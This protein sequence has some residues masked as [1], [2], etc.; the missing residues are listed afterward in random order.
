MPITIALQLGKKAG[1]ENQVR[2]V[3]QNKMFW[4]VEIGIELSMVF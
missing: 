3:G 2:A 1:A 4:C